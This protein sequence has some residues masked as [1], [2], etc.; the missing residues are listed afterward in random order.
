[1]E[2]INAGEALHGLGIMHASVSE[3]NEEYQELQKSIR[4]IKDAAMCFYHEPLP[5]V[6]DEDQIELRKCNAC[7]RSFELLSFS[8]TQWQK[9]ERVCKG[10]ILVRDT[11][12]KIGKV[13][14]T[15]GEFQGKNGEL[16][17][18]TSALEPDTEYE[19]KVKRQVK[20]KGKKGKQGKGKKRTVEENHMI[21]GGHLQLHLDIDKEVVDMPKVEVGG[22]A[23]VGEKGSGPDPG[24]E[25][26][27][28]PQQRV[29]DDG[30]R[31][32]TCTACGQH[33]VKASFSKNQWAKVRCT[34]IF[35]YLH[36]TQ[37]HPL[38]LLC[39]HFTG[40]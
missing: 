26:V 10:C 3:S 16:M 12:E 20:S 29:Q 33:H 37:S 21:V 9:K 25:A 19:V 15:G 35:P 27:A 18:L 4:Q 14:I 39:S 38:R 5:C 11:N 24:A 36:C 1:V 32:K 34:P 23:G 8:K 2:N 30:V 40:A 22:G 28:T 6:K 17:K 31:K 7:I 13:A